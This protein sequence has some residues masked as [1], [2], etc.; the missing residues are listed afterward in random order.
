MVTTL[1]P[2]ICRQYPAEQV[3]FAAD[4]AAEEAEWVGAFL[5]VA[6]L[7]PPP[8]ETRGFPPGVLLD[9]GGMVRLRAW[10]VAG[11]DMHRR[12]GLP[13]AREALEHI[14]GVLTAAAANPAEL[15]RAGRLGRA[16]FG[17]RMSRFAWAGPTELRADVVLDDP[18][19]DVL[20]EA[21]V[22]LLRPTLLRN[23][24]VR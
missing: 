8:G 6:G 15:T 7:A 23:K 4:G 11:L 9:L 17:L 3:R 1:S 16:V 12:A 22:D 13:T 2:D 20:L 24:T 18:D 14:V 5:A 21:L 19:E 10:E